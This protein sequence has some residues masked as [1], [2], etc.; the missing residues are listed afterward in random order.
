ML[1][2]LMSSKHSYVERSPSIVSITYF[3]VLLE[4][5]IIL[6]Y[7][8]AGSACARE[9]FLLNTNRTIFQPQNGESKLHYD[10]TMMISNLYQT[11]T[12]GSICIVLAH[13]NQQ[14]MGRHDAPHG[15]ILIPSQQV[16]AFSLYCCLGSGEAA[17]AKLILF[18]L[19]LTMYF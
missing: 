4:D 7:V 11:I 14:S 12:L 17:N 5:T 2:L 8:L 19:T 10:D 9:Q 15:K 18:G 13:L 16:F 1:I 6:S 3:N